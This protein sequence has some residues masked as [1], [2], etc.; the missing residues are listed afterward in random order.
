M[1]PARGRPT[2]RPWRIGGTRLPAILLAL[3]VAFVAAGC[4]G[5]DGPPASPAA[6]ATAAPA[7]PTGPARTERPRRTPDAA[8][9]PRPGRTPRPVPATSDAPGGSGGVAGSSA[10]TATPRPTVPPP[11]L[12]PGPDRRRA[13]AQPEVFGFL[14]HWELANA[15]TLDLDA[16]T[17]LAWFGVE[18]GSRGSL[19]KTT[20][21]GVPVPGW[22]GW[23][24]PEWIALAERA[25]ARDVRVV[26]TIQRFSWTDGQRKRT[27]RLLRN[28]ANRIRLVREIMEAIGDGRADGVNLD[29]EPMPAEV[30]AEFTQL[31][32][33]LRAAMNAVDPRLQLTF[34][35]A[36]SMEG[37]DIEAL[38][39]DDAA[40]AVFVMGYE[41]LTGAAA[42]T[43]SNAP[44][45][46]P[47][48]EDG[49]DLASTTDATIARIPPG[50]VILGLPWYGRVW[51]TYRDDPGSATRGGTRF[52]GSVTIFYRD[53]LA[54]AQRT[55]RRWDPE[56]ASAW[57]LYPAVLTGCAACP[58][59]W[60]QLWYDDVDATMEK[61][62]F[63]QDRE[64]RGVGFWALGYQGAGP[65][66]WSAIRHTLG[67]A[68]DGEP[69]TGSVRIDPDWQRGER[70]GLPVVGEAVRLRLDATDRGGSGVAFV[71]IG[72]DAELRADGQLRWGMTYPDARAV[73]IDPRTGDPVYAMATPRPRSEREE[74]SPSPSASP[75]ASASASAVPGASASALPSPVPSPVP[76]GA[77]S[78]APSAPA[79]ASPSASPSAAASASPLASA[80]PSAA[81]LPSPTPE[82]DAQP[83]PRTLWI[84][85]RDVAGSWSAPVELRVWFKPDE[86]PAATP[87]PAAEASLAPP[88]LV[89][90]VASEDAEVEEP[91][92]A[93]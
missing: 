12:T 54:Q 35:A 29:F 2:V 44:L 64:L 84:Q 66:M 28:P 65:E 22:A 24:S 8:R 53:A 5:S 69:P 4:A 68:T 30:S 39:A 71:R 13:L 1:Q 63:A 81:P 45:R 34:D 37:Y 27:V 72:P 55:G 93:P 73:T 20:G 42:R 62:R 70:R 46:K 67:G 41:F 58:V 82:P 31:V 85:W 78:I 47:E 15:D 51:S 23:E 17:T 36:P 49:D 80:A 43:G 76:S 50:R 26:L 75:S 25:R 83:G 21:A 52:P 32:R 61:I 59:T 91:S 89:P 86:R 19:V 56:E 38:T 11:S 92:A 3:V 74:A 33:E 48:G 88:P 40:D 90:G 9:T 79:A 77:P 87:E 16:L 10:P 57:T 60:R 14:P 6:T 18:A 7:S